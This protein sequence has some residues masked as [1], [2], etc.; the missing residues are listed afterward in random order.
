MN[1]STV[2]A[3]YHNHK[4]YKYYESFER[5]YDH[6][7]QLKLDALEM[8]EFRIEKLDINKL[9]NKIDGRGRP[10]KTK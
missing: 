10:R 9:P 4:P 3:I 6:L 7:V 2:Y 8:G 1:K 5:A